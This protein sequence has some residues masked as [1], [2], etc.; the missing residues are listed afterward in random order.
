MPLPKRSIIASSSTSFSVSALDDA[1]AADRQP[2]AALVRHEAALGDADH[3][4]LDLVARR[5]STRNVEVVGR[6]RLRA[7]APCRGRSRGTRSSAGSSRNSPLSTAL[8][9]PKSTVS[10]LKSRRFDDEQEVG[11]APGRDDAEVAL[12][13]EGLGVVDR[14]H[15]DRVH[16]RDALRDRDADALVDRPL[17]QQLL[18]RGEVGAEA[19]AARVDAELGVRRARPRARPGS[20]SPGAS[21]ASSP[22]APCSARPAPRPISWSV[23][24]PDRDVRLQL[25]LG[26]P[27]S[28]AG[29]HLALPQRLVEQ[30]EELRV[31]LDDRQVR[32]LLE[33]VAARPS[34]ASPSGRQPR[35]RRSA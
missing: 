30:V 18:G 24:T 21:A 34:R 23:V 26:D 22:S 28:V 5:R 8:P 12:G 2:R 29:D 17:V 13:V 20:R 19:E 4:H 31:V 9:P 15:L 10:I 33:P 3:A 14:R 35:S 25:A 7:A 11:V 6:D 1:V 27:R 32:R 16:G